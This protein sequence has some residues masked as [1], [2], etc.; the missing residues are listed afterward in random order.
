MVNRGHSLIARLASAVLNPIWHEIGKQKECS[1]LD[2]T[3]FELAVM[4]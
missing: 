1:S 3:Y 4:D 2:Q